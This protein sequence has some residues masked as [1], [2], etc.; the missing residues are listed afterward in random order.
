M[1]Y[2]LL[3]PGKTFGREK[4]FHDLG[5]EPRSAFYSEHGCGSRAPRAAI[6]RDLSH[7]RRLVAERHAVVVHVVGTAP[8]RLGCQQQGPYPSFPTSRSAASRFSICSV[9]LLSSASKFRSTAA[10][11][12]SSSAAFFCG[13]AGPFKCR[14]SRCYGPVPAL[15]FLFM[16]CLFPPGFTLT[17]LLL[18]FGPCS[19]L[20]SCVL[21]ELD[22]RVL[23]LWRALL[24]WPFDDICELAGKGDVLGEGRG[25][26]DRPP[27]NDTASPWSPQPPP[28]HRKP[29][30]SPDGTGCSLSPMPPAQPSLKG[31]LLRGRRS[32]LRS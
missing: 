17:L 2:S 16:R 6:C 10:W 15:A 7:Y 27:Q 9:H 26:A 22:G 4:G 3:K 29:S 19:S 25:C 24:C 8:G 14:F 28:G 31:P 1:S 13:L 23:G 5:E 20:T 18:A 30:R 12:L 11:V 32:P 21:I